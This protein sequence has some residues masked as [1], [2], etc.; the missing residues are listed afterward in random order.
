MN[1]ESILKC[2]GIT[3][4]TECTCTSRTQF[5]YKCDFSDITS[6]KNKIITFL[7]LQLLQN[8]YNQHNTITPW[9]HAQSW[10]KCVWIPGMYTYRSSQLSES[11]WSVAN[12]H[13]TKD[14]WCTYPVIWLSTSSR[15]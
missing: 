1:K 11:V 14:I 9:A 12:E 7:L 13:S 2:M 15:V 3:L 6:G 10:T 4:V 8:Y 5:N